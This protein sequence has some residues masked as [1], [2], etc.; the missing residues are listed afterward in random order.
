MYSPK[1][2]YIVYCHDCWWSDRWDPLDHGKE[3]DFS[4]P[5]FEQFSELVHRSPLRAQPLDAITGK[6]SPFTNFV[7]HSKNCYLIFYSDSC[8]DTAYGFFLK[9][10]KKAYDCSMT[11]DCENV[12]DITNGLKNYNVFTGEGNVINCLDSYFIKD[13]R[14]CTNC[15]GAVNMRNK[16]Y[17][18]FNEQ[19]TKEEYKKR[20]SEIDLGSYT[21]YE[22]MREKAFE[23]WK[24]NL[25]RPFYDDFSTN[26]SGN[27]V[28]QSKNCK[29]CYDVGYAEDS[30][31]LMLIKEGIVK[32]CY[33]YVDWGGNAERIYES[34][35]IGL[36]TS[37]VRFSQ[38]GGHGLRSA[39]YTMLCFGGSDL[40][41]CV[42]L[43][44][45]NYC[46]LNKQYTKEEYFKLREK[47]IQHMNEMLYVD[48]VGNTYSYGEFF[49]LEFSPHAYNDTLAYY[50]LPK[51]REVASAEGLT[52]LEQDSK[53]Y[54]I[55]LKTENVPDYIK[56]VKDEILNEVIQCKTC[57]RGFKIIHQEFQ[58][59]QQHSLPL[60]RQCPFCRIDDK[61][62]RWVWQMTL[63][64]R[65]CAKCSKQFRTHYDEARAPL[66]YCKECYVK[67]V[68]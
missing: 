9:G 50:F 68:I 15:F 55:T 25:P 40:F 61:I 29:D 33:D 16:E 47:I 21:T 6:L 14:N 35:T 66:I 2:N 46:I 22:T 54:S 26:V 62:K 30:K 23:L 11:W 52:W 45:K 37:D 31:F 38:D 51:T 64:D 43:R 42:G 57:I 18:F 10:N 39:D 56:D 27:Y 34:V 63:H 3:Y 5:F 28:L 12:F 49:P 8:E 59:L 41:G 53:E 65:T 48:T 36:N 19:L 13:C 1:A 20:L 4:R 44:N 7:G 32:D 60:P 58:F 24:T 67:E 17:I